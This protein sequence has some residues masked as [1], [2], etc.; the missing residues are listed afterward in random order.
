MIESVNQQGIRVVLLGASF[1]TGNL[2]VSALAWSSLYLIRRKWPAAKIVLLGVGKQ[3]AESQV[4]LNDRPEIFLS[5]PV[6][7]CINI[8]A[9]HH[10]LGLGAAVLLSRFV[11]FCGRWFDRVPSGVQALLRCNLICD[12]TGGDSFSDIYGLPRFLRGYLLKRI[13]QLTGKPFILLPQTYGPFET[14]L[15][16]MLARH[17]LGNCKVIFSRDTEGLRTVCDLIGSSGKAKLCPDV[18]FTLKPLRPD[19]VQIRQLE[20]LK[21]KGKQIVGFNVS[22]LLYHG[23]YSRDNMFGLSCDYQA[24]VATIL[25]WFY[26]HTDWCMMLVPHVVPQAKWVVEDDLAASIQVTETLPAECRDRVFVL[27]RGYDQNEIKY[28]IGFS[29]FFIGARMHATIAALSQG[30]PAIG[31]AYSRK[32]V[33]VFATVGVVD[34]VLDLRSLNEQEILSRIEDIFDR[35]YAITTILQQNVPV[36]KEKVQGLFEGFEDLSTDVP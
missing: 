3:P 16:Q 4:Y 30:I 35:R 18:A 22:G 29:D 14:G 28:F 11:P 9:A 17:V 2:G 36:L 1:A 32:F 20:Q 31:L 12:I 26:R 7:Y 10:I 5:W 27:E 19:S 33:G 21:A 6:R 8:F 24:L 13:C 25:L 23:G 34:C 15:A